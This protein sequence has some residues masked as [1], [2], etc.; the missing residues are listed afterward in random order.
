[1]E[2]ISPVLATLGLSNKEITVYLA[3]LSLGEANAT[4]LSR[5][6]KIER[7]LVYYV[8]EQLIERGL[9]SYK[10]RNKV[11]YFS[12]YPP[13]KLLQDLQDKEEQL[14]AI[15]PSLEQLQHHPEEEVRVEVYRGFEGAKAVLND[16]FITEKK[17]ILAMGEEGQFQESYGSQ[18]PQYLRRLKEHKLRERIIAREDMRG[19]IPG[20]LRSRYRYVPK[21]LLSPSTTVI[22]GNKIV[23]TLWDKPLYNIVIESTKVA[24]SYR[25][26][27]EYLWKN[28][29]E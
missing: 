10:E 11:R 14:K 19:R 25:K 24:Q 26:Y 7:T 4:Q 22:Y 20:M 29:K 8:V 23:I 21:E 18:V 2:K 28:A 12:A 13:S 17:E 3:L 1:M 5:N 27:F 6:S 16:I 15:L 9:I